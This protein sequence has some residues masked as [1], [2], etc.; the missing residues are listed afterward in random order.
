MLALAAAVIAAAVILARRPPMP[1]LAADL[2]D[3][4]STRVMQAQIEQ[5]AASLAALAGAFEERRRLE[6]Q[7]VDAVARVE[8]LMAGS[9]ARGRAGENLLAAALMEFPAEMV[10]REFRVGGHVCE[11]A[12]RMPDGKLLPID[13]KW[14]ASDLV[15]ELEATCERGRRDELGRQIDKAVCGR[16]GEVTRYI[17][18]SLTIPL[19]VLAVP[20]GAF[21]CCRKSHSLAQRSRVLIVSY[22]LAVPY[23]LGLWSLYRTYDR[24]VDG[25]EI[26]AAVHEVSVNL[27][28]MGERIEGQLS[29]GLRMAGAAAIEMRSLVAGAQLSLSAMR[30]CRATAQPSAEGPGP[31]LPDGQ[32]GDG[33]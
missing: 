26:L 22:S 16:I 23:L 24:Q 13:S 30:R 28:E 12:L 19:A 27:T 31:A 1:G 9:Y 4:E 15:T 2:A 21:A 20:D 32:M 14:P 5:T 8:R 25:S 18:P 11:F 10:V 3:A 6:E 17:D 29:T 7:T 33:R